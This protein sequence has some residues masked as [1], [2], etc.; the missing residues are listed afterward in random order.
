MLEEV[1]MVSLLVSP[2]VLKVRIPVL[3]LWRLLALGLSSDRW[4]VSSV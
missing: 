2:S 1:P 4:S 3:N